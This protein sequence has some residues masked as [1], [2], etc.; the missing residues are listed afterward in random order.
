VLG[1]ATFLRL[2]IWRF[3]DHFGCTTVVCKLIKLSAGRMDFLVAG[4]SVSIPVSCRAITKKSARLA[5]LAALDIVLMGI[6]YNAV[7]NMD[8]AFVGANHVNNGTIP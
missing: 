5:A 6:D 1:Y 8:E 3:G 4:S 7:R 2:Q